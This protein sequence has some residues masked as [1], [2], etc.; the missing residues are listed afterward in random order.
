MSGLVEVARF[1][2]PVRAHLARAYLESFGLHPVLFDAQSFGIVE[3][4]PNP[5]RLMVIGEEL[6]E[7]RRLLVDY[8]P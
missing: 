8:K 1:D 7:A 2:T 4:F 5:S 3:G 6:E